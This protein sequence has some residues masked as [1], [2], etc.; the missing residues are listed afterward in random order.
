[1]HFLLKKDAQKFGGKGK[2]YYLCTRNRE[3]NRKQNKKP[4][5]AVVQLG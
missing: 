2:S 1:M 4:K 3:T 5:G